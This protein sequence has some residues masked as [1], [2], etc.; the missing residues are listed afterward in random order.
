MGD[1]A[2]GER[3]GSGEQSAAGERATAGGG[4]A[5]AGEPLLAVAD[6][7]IAFGGVQALAGVSLAV[8]AGEAVGLVGPNGAGKTT[9]FECIGGRLRPDGGSVRFAGADLAGVPA[10]RRSRLGI[11]RTFQ[12]VEVFPEL[13]PVEHVLVAA[14]ARQG[15]GMLW[16]DLVRRGTPRPDEVE[17]ARALVGMVGLADAA[18]VPVAALGLG[19]TR[20]VELARALASSPR[21]LLADEPSSGLDTTETA[22]IAA[23]LRRIQRERGVAVL[24][25]EHDL[26][27]VRRAVDRVVVLDSG[28]V[29]ADGPFALVVADPAVRRAYLGRSA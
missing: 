9:L 4:T 19:H 23:L 27:L 15:G 10:H 8:A 3:A 1:P 28:H 26:A 29:I 6:V 18:D 12:R 20:L 13:T 21:L 2:A 5:V 17:Q 11:A 14:R 7:S 22:V 24:L 16:R 25:V